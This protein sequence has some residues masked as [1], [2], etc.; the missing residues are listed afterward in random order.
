MRSIAIDILFIHTRPVDRWSLGNINEDG[1]KS[2]CE[3]PRFFQEFIIYNLGR[4]AGKNE[5]TREHI[6]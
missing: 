5:F 2:G 6:F 3:N 4:S 1:K